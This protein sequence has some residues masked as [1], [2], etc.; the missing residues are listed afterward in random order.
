GLVAAAP[1]RAQSMIDM[2]AAMGVHGA[3]SGTASS[4]ATTALKVR[5]TVS[6]QTS[7]AGGTGG[8]QEGGEFK[9]SGGA[10]GQGW[11]TASSSSAG[12]GKSGWASNSTSAGAGSKGWASN[13][14]TGSGGSKGWATRGSTGGTMTARAS[15]T[16]IP[17]ASDSG[18]GPTARDRATAPP[19]S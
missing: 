11:A 3:L 5:E 12:G 8:W 9:S 2:N 7:S 6:N 16:K 17:S 1:A 15:T 14:S 10:G 18:N 13:S 4:S 19:S